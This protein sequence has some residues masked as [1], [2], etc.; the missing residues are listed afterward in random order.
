MWKNWIQ[1]LRLTIY[2]NKICFEVEWLG[3]D[4][5]EIHKFSAC[6][7]FSNDQPCWM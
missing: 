1:F 2:H 5:V 4:S 3:G 7:M 6:I